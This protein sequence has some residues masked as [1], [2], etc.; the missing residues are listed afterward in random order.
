[1]ILDGVIAKDGQIIFHS[2]HLMRG[3][4]RASTMPIVRDLA[5]E[6]WIDPDVVPRPV[7]TFGVAME[8]AELGAHRHA[9]GQILL[10]LRG[11]LS[12]EVE[13]GLWIVPPQSAIWIPGGELH[14]IKAAGKIEGYNAFIDAANASRLPARCCTIS[15][16]PLLRELL[17]RAAS[18]P[19]F[20]PDGGPD[21]HLMTLLIDEVAAAP[22]GN[23]HLPMPADGRLRQ[24]AEMIIADPAAGGTVATWAARA[25]LSERT[26][27][28]R[29]NRET[30]MSFSRWRQQIN[31]MVALQWLAEGRSI[32]QVAADLGYES[33][34]SFVTRFRKSLGAPPGRYMA[35]RHAGAER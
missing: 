22:I 8:A 26:F 31:I 32:Q 28:R 4:A 14:A 34:S 23:L 27:A 1:L 11:V 17:I 12:C 29:L 33:A 30:G 6:D 10:A 2:R 15:A 9:K 35:E 7:I 25:G 13:G 3:R 5:A 21:A 20:Y 18:L 19:V 24:I 16:S